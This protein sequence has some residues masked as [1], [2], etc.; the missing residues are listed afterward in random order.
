MRSVNIMF[1]DKSA[2]RVK[3]DEADAL[4]RAGK[5]SYISHTV[6][7]AVQAGVPLDTI[8]D[9]RD[10]RAIKLQIQSITRKHRRE[11]EEPQDEQPVERRLTKAE[12]RQKV[13]EMEASR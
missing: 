13:V 3:A 1:R 8:K 10:D 11:R 2:R 4:V 12:R 5:A 7:K 9:R 6:Y